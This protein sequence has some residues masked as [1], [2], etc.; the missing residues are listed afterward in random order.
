MSTRETVASAWQNLDLTLCQPFSGPLFQGCL[1][2]VQTI[3]GG[4]YLRVIGPFCQIDCGQLRPKIH[5]HLPLCLGDDGLNDRR[6]L[7]WGDIGLP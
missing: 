1:H 3:H 5:L 6:G 4:P 2:L 7:L